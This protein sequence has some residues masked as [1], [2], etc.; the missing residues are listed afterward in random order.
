MGL[1]PCRR[2]SLRPYYAAMEADDIPV[3]IEVNED[4]KTGI[5]LIPW[6]ELSKVNGE[7]FKRWLDKAAKVRAEWEAKGYRCY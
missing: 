1:P 3:R 4:A 6:N 7:A 2:R 5:I